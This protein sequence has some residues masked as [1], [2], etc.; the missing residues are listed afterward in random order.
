MPRYIIGFISQ[1]VR[2][3]FQCGRSKEVLYWLGRVYAAG[4]G[5][6]LPPP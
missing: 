4:C 1:L 2:Y 3:A 5:V 6:L